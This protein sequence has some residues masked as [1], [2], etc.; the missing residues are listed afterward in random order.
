MLTVSSPPHIYGPDTVVRRMRDV[1]VALA[2]SCVL[3]VYYYGT[4]A[5][6]LMLIS[7]GSAVISEFLYQRVAGK[8]VTIDDFSAVVTGVLLALNLPPDAPYWLPAVGG[9]FAIVAVKQLF[10]GLGANFVN[11]ALA[12]RAFLLAS[13][14]A[15]MTYWTL[16]DTSAGAT[17]LALIKSDAGFTPRAADYHALIFGKIGG[18]IGE[19]SA[20]A[21]VAGGAY[22]LARRVISWHIPAC[23]VGSFAL[24]SFLL[25]RDG[26][27]YTGTP[28][29]LLAGGLLLGAFFMAT[30]YATS[31]IS[32]AGKIIMGVG[33]GLL[34]V[35]IRFHSGYPEGVC[36]AILIMNLF[37][38][39]IDKYVR[40]RIYGKKRG[41]R[42]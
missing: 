26:P 38:P 36:F 29:E 10:G 17:Y 35:I 11:P 21:I 37:V 30:D 6:F 14:P 33:C 13:F 40:P 25:G 42:A 19:T 23:F 3:G 20:L 7:A 18:C 32:P 22:L 9:V 5:L 39:L 1:L 15:F 12:A 34:T 8:R 4:H 2:P 41:K 27:F 28:F 16:P 31:P 24:L